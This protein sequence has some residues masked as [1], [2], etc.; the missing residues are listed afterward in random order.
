MKFIVWRRFKWLFIGLIILILVGLFLGILLYSL[1]V[2]YDSGF[3]KKYWHTTDKSG[4]NMNQENYINHSLIQLYS[5]HELTICFSLPELHLN[6]N[7]EA[8]LMEN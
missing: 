3:F 4:Y 6:E 8:V 7:C 5:A 1:P 2:S